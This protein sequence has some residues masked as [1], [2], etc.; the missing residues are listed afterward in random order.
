ME[1]RQAVNRRLT[2]TVVAS[3]DAPAFD[4]SSVDGWAVA[5][6]SFQGGERLL[7]IAEGSGEAGLVSDQ[8]LADGS[9]VKVMTGAPIP[10]GADAVFKVEDVSVEL[11]AAR[12]PAKGQPGQFVRQRGSD[13]RKGQVL[14]EQGSLIE[15]WNIASLA[16]GGVEEVEVVKPL[17]V[18]VL[19]TGN[20][21]C[22]DVSQLEDGKT[23]DVNRVSLGAQLASHRVDVIDFGICG[24]NETELF[25][26]LTEMS[27]KCDLVLTTGGVS[28]GDFDF[29]KK[30]ALQTDTLKWFQLAMKPGKPLV[31]GRLNR[32]AFVGLPGNPV[33]SLVGF[34]MFVRP[35]LD[36]R[37]DHQIAPPKLLRAKLHACTQKPDDG[38]VHFKRA[39]LVQNADNDLVV[40]V[41]SMQD[42]HQTM[43]LNSTNCLVKLTRPGMYE[44]NVV[45]EVLLCEDLI[46]R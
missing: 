8:V 26:K 34:E 3:R 29:V 30:L 36:R 25:E 19:S 5:T 44:P 32:A 12:F 23:I 27:G 37:P 31:A 41:H 15:P 42:S 10:P 18:G 13:I 39:L 45:V 28:M 21:L 35:I 38:K 9:C 24:D 43:G 6:K 46:R 40:S 2:E 1:L 33:S 7:R 11:G 20:E 22:D 14:L 17:V 16:A 4:C